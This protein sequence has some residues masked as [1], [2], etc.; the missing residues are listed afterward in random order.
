MLSNLETRPCGSFR[1][2]EKDVKMGFKKGGAQ[3]ACAVTKET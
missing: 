2:R 1:A 3:G